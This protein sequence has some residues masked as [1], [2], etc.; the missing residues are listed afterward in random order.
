MHIKTINLVYFSPTKT[1]K[2]IIE[3]I[4][5][6]IGAEIINEIDLTTNCSN[7]KIRIE[8]NQF[9]IFG[10]PVYGGRI[11]ETA[12]KRF[13]NISS[14]NS[15]S[16]VIAVYGN[17][18]YEDALTELK[19]ISQSC[20]FKTIAAGAFIGEH[21]FSFN[22]VEVA[23]DRPDKDDLNMAFSFGKQ[24]HDK[25]SNENYSSELKVPGNNPYRKLKERSV[26]S[27]DTLHSDC[28]LCG[29]C[30]DVC[31]TGAI[32]LNSHI[33]TVK[34]S[35]IWCCACVKSC[36]HNARIMNNSVVGDLQEWLIE[37]YSER[38]EPELFL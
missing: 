25:L 18:A 6:G 34:E 14:D 4:A 11:P 37:N 26:L 1:T 24:I 2:K 30:V 28:K 5:Q 23:K 38:K 3:S 21:S 33:E 12:T 36:E 22:N 8:K 13:K 15:L 10:A 29:V 19:D 17:R 35:C 9:T 32:T 7:N 20:G 27:P 31:P 16:A